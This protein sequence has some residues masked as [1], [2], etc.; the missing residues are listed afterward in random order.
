MGTNNEGMIRI[1]SVIFDMYETLVNDPQ[2]LW[3]DGF[4]GIIREQALDTTAE[5]LGQ[6]WWPKESEFRTNRIKPGVPFRTY[7]ETWRDAFGHAFANLGIEGDPAA[8]AGSYIGYVSRQDPYPETLEALKTI[9]GRWR[10]AILSNADDD[11]LLPNL[12]RLGLEFDVVL[13]SEQARAYKP[14][15][16]LFREVLH[17]LRVAPQESVYVGDRQVEDVH[18]ATEVGINAIW[19]NRSGAPPDAHLP[20]PVCQ[21][22]SLLELP[23]I[24]L[25][26]PPTEDGAR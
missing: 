7:Y 26:W 24:L 18:G 11:F 22:S 1:T 20:E 19:I 9:Q 25:A 14:H 15:P 23:N 12:E 3:K 21:I 8:A 5:L 17:R 2:H 6:E 4:E 13:S 10:T 16:E